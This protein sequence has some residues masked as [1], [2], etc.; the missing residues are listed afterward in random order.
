MRPVLVAL[1]AV[2]ALLAPAPGSAQ[3][4]LSFQDLA[5][6]INLRDL[7]QID[8]ESGTRTAGRLTRLTRDEMSVETGAGEKRFTSATVREVAVRRQSHR[9]GVLLGAGI[10]AA[11]GA[12]AACAGPD[13]TECADGPILIGALGAGV[14]LAVGALIPRMTTVYRAREEHA[15]RVASGVCEVGRPY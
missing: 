5:L 13:R 7:L 6:R 9:M 11:L 1:P 4:I 10:G 14:G 8:D 3:S 2:L 15:P 12:L